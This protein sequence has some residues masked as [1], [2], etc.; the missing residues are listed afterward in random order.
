MKT[1]LLLAIG[2]SLVGCGA[3]NVGI[4]DFS[5][6]EKALMVPLESDP[7]EQID[8]LNDTIEGLEKLDQL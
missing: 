6:E 5:T 2:F 4:K 1:F 8:L 3:N 7:I